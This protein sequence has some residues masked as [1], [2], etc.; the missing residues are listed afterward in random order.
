M[1][2]NARQAMLRVHKENVHR[3]FTYYYLNTC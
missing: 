1:C 3:I 2:Q